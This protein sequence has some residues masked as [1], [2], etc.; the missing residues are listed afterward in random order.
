MGVTVSMFV[1]VVDDYD[2]GIAF[3]RDAIGLERNP[4]RVNRRV[5][6]Y[7][8]L[9]MNYKVGLFNNVDFQVVVPSYQQFMAGFIA[10]RF[11][12][13]P[14]TAEPPEVAERTAAVARAVAPATA[15]TARGRGRALRMDSPCSE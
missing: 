15:T 6:E 8:V 4:E 2:R 9:N 10:L 12:K 14:A 1:L 5:K 13:Y 3:Y 7:E 11:L